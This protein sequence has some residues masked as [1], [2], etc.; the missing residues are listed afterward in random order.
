[1]ASGSRGVI[2]LMCQCCCGDLKRDGKEHR[3]LPHLP[4]FFFF[5]PLSE[6]EKRNTIGDLNN[7]TD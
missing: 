5:E 1:M 6:N 3:A 7:V 2:L 4:Q